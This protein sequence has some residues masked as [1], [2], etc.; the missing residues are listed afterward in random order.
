VADKQ[1]NCSLWLLNTRRN[2]IFITLH[3]M[4][5]WSSNENSVCLSVCMSNAWFVKNGR[6]IGLDFY[7]I[8][9]II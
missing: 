9:K 1:V 2:D 3:G 6:K 4:Q 8:R 5:T 7:T